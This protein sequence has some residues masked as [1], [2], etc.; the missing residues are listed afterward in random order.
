MPPQDT[1]RNSTGTDIWMRLLLGMCGARTF[2]NYKI[3]PRTVVY[4]VSFS[5]CRNH[6]KDAGVAQNVFPQM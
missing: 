1:V 6:G 4:C 5:N 2:E 3:S